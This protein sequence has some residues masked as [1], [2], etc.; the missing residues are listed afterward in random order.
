[1][2]KRKKVVVGIAGVAIV[3]GLLSLVPDPPHKQEASPSHDS[4]YKVSEAEERQRQL[5]I[6]RFN[7]RGREINERLRINYERGQ[8]ACDRLEAATGTKPRS[9]SRPRPNYVEMMSTAPLE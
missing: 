3:I 6:S 2:A 8:A 7:E 4:A 5:I 1:M 9:C